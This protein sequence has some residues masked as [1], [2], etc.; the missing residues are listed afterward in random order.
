MEIRAT[1]ASFVILL[2]LLLAAF[3][4][5]PTMAFADEGD[6][7]ATSDANAAQVEVDEAENAAEE[8]AAADANADDE[9][10]VAEPATDAETAEPASAEPTATEAVDEDGQ[11]SAEVAADDQVVIEEV[12]STDATETAEPAEAAVQEEKVETVANT[13]A[14]AAAAATAIVAKKST[15][16]KKAAKKAS[17]QAVENGWYYIQSKKLLSTVLTAVKSGKNAIIKNDK[18]KTYQ[19]WK[20]VYNASK[21][22]YTLYNKSL[23][24]YLT[25]TSTK[26]GANVKLKAGK[27]KD[28]LWKITSKGNAYIFKSAACKYVLDINQGKKIKSGANVDISKKKGTGAKYQLWYLLPVD[29]DFST[30][31]VTLADGYYTI[32]LTKAATQTVTVPDSSKANGKQL[33]S[34][35]YEQ[36]LNQKYYVKSEG[37]GTYTIRSVA[38]ALYMTMSGSDVV[39]Q[40]KT[41]DNSQKWRAVSLGN[42]IAF[43]NVAT[44]KSLSIK[45]A[46]TKDDAA[47]VAASPAN[48]P[49]QRFNVKKKQ[50][51]DNG[52]YYLHMTTASKK[53]NVA[54]VNDGSKED[55][56][57]V[58]AQKKTYYNDNGTFQVKK[59]S[60]GVF[61]LINLNSGKTLVDNGAGKA[62]QKDSSEDN[63]KW[64]AVMSENGGVTFVNVA[65]GKAL[66][67]ATSA[68]STLQTKVEDG[69]VAQTWHVEKAQVLKP[70]QKKALKKILQRGSKRNYYFFAD[71]SIPRMMIWERASKNSEWKIK[72]DYII[73]YGRFEGGVS[74]TPLLDD[75]IHTHRRWLDSEGAYG[76]YWSA[77]YATRWSPTAWFHSFTHYWKHSPRVIDSRLGMAVSGGCIRMQDQYSK[78]IYEHH[79]QIKRA[80]VTV[81]NGGKYHW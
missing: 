26:K 41:S 58:S 14:P 2:T 61:K 23:K 50:V 1:K 74:K 30:S 11:E 37:D 69:T 5:L 9:T 47:A 36:G 33:T 72:M 49:A 70:Y 32:G 42:G 3:I 53:S 15:P 12:A 73:S 63:A 34:N 43:V 76:G 48:K 35:A 45:G 24:K 7:A 19:Q 17:G 71:L 18:A 8:V 6:Q 52:Y 27:G 51:I 25:I 21:K 64:K 75:V 22:A 46:S 10:P 13:A 78:W 56:A 68:G 38:S 79:K 65:T 62:L 44:G 31:N 20:I 4:T 80:S 39:Q 29:V 40:T 57:K 59:V 55:N 77:P 28:A 66:V 54:T 60:N 81:W 67:A 16:A